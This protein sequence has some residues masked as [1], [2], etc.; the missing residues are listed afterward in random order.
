MKNIILISFLSFFLIN[1]D[2]DDNT[3]ALNNEFPTEIEYTLIGKGEDITGGDSVDSANLVFNN[4]D[5]W[6]DFLATID[7]ISNV[8]NTFT[9]TEIDFA[10]YQIIAVID[11]VKTTG[12]F[13]INI[14]NV[15][16]FSDNIT[17]EVERPLPGGDS[18]VMTQP[19]HIIKIP[20][21]SKPINF[22][23]N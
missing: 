22:T 11:E 17:V 9:E 4:T 16:E 12:G 14:T 10:N 2:G 1:C 21:S 15:I 3:T 23:I 18:A 5:E 8:S 6:N 20:K 7:D 13:S 19:Y